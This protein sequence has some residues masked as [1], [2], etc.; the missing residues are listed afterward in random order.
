MIWYFFKNGSSHLIVAEPTHLM[1]FSG[2]FLGQIVASRCFV[3][4]WWESNPTSFAKIARTMTLKMIWLVG[5]LKKV[6][7]DVISLYQ[8]L[9]LGVDLFCLMMDVF[10][11][12]A[13]LEYSAMMPN[14]Q[15]LTIFVWVEFQSSSHSK[16]EQFSFVLVMQSIGWNQL[17]LGA[18]LFTFSF[19]QNSKLFFFQINC[20]SWNLEVAIHLINLLGISWCF[21]WECTQASWVSWA[22][23]MLLQV[24]LE[25]NATKIGAKV[26]DFWKACQP[27]QPRHVWIIWLENRLQICGQLVIWSLSRFFF[28]QVVDNVIFRRSGK[29]FYFYTMS[30]SM[31]WAF[32]ASTWMSRGL[33]E[34]NFCLGAGKAAICRPCHGRSGRFVGKASGVGEGRNTIWQTP[35]KLCGG[36]GSRVWSTLLQSWTCWRWCWNVGLESRASF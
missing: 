8:P 2:F 14:G 23:P 6:I 12:W 7:G 10:G 11:G 35:T 34:E 22:F 18:F 13:K 26:V 27:S 32:T 20:Q 16:G 15:R 19:L 1:N 21:L 30:V 9:E 4:T 33:R 24:R 31:T 3:C 17:L 29:W 28:P 5:N 36:R 25:S